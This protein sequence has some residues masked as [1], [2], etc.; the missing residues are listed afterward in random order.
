MVAGDLYLGQARIGSETTYATAATPTR[1]IY[2]RSGS[3]VAPG[4]ENPT[5][6]FLT[7]DRMQTLAATAGVQQP[8]GPFTL[9]VGAGEILEFLSIG[10]N[11]TPTISTPVGATDA[12]LHVYTPGTPKSGTLQSDDGA[13][14]WQMTGV[15]AN[16]LR[17][18]GSAAQ[19]GENLLSGDLFGAAL[20]QTALS[21]TVTSREPQFFSGWETALAIDDPDGTDN[22]GTTAIAAAQSIINY[23]CEFGQNLGRKYTA[24][25]TQA[26]LRAVLGR[27]SGTGSLTFEASGAQALTE[28]NHYKAA[29]LRR[30]SLKLGD[31]VEIETGF[32]HYVQLDLSLVWTS[33]TLLGEDAGTRT[34]EANYALVKDSVNSFPYRIQVQTD[35]TAA[36]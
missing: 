36:F 1:R 18:A 25:N 21:G 29:D 24:A 19:G 35:R 2:W 11:G 7:G 31:N 12:R 6:D 26:M 4:Q 5:H 17:F 13:R 10:V 30:V 16:T 9:P 33:M 28:Y 14:P 8:A 32:T 27:L 22:Y 23:T 34:Y 20:T 15:Y 3:G